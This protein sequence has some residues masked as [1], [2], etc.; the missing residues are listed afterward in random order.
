MDF[1]T[2]V[3]GIIWIAIVAFRILDFRT[4][5]RRRAGTAPGAP[6]R[7][8][9]GAARGG[10]DRAAPAPAH[11]PAQVAQEQRAEVL[12]PDD[13]W[14]VLT[15]ERRQPAPLPM[16]TEPE[17]EDRTTSG[18]TEGWDYGELEDEQYAPETWRPSE[19]APDMARDHAGQLG[20]ESSSIAGERSGAP[21]PARSN[22][23]LPE[24]A[25]GDVPVRPRY[26]EIVSL[27]EQYRPGEREGVASRERSS[28]G[29]REVRAARSV[30]SAAARRRALRHAVVLQEVL[31]PPKGLE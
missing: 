17:A 21:V 1:E 22:G 4:G 25:A 7:E 3:V 11:P 6:R 27:E 24:I 14:E 15:G 13:L 28:V 16:P 9:S 10:E 12:L 18:S 30:S 20:G 31:G 23:D 19:P 26:R 2:I 8:E 5:Q 29:H